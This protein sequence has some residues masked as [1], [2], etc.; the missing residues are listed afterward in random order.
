MLSRRHW[1]RSLTV[2][3]L[4]P[5]NWR[6]CDPMDAARTGA[7][8]TS[9]GRCTPP[10]SVSAVFS[11]S[12]QKR[13]RFYRQTPS[14]TDI[15]GHLLRLRCLIRAGLGCVVASVLRLTPKTAPKVD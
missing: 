10:P 8:C 9:R 2:E 7:V 6:E 1:R 11:C 14:F 3:S 15:Y 4:E 5:Y 13:G 12:I